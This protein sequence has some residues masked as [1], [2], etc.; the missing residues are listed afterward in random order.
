MR[1]T[2]FLS[3]LWAVAA[4]LF[5]GVSVCGAQPG[6]HATQIE[7]R[8]ADPETFH[9]Q[10][11]TTPDRIWPGAE[12]WPNPME[13]W[14]VHDGRLENLS[15]GVDRN[16]HLLTHVLG[17]PRGS[18]EVRVRTGILETGEQGSVGFRIGQREPEIDDY[19]GNVFYGEGLDAA[20]SVDGTLMLA[21]E[22]TVLDEALPME[23]L[24][25]RLVGEPDE[26][27]YRLTLTVHHVDTGETLGRLSAEDIAGDQVV[28]NVAL[29]NNHTAGGSRFWFSD[30]HVS[31][32]K[33]VAF[34]DRAFGPILWSM[35]SLSNSRGDDGHVLKLSAQMPPLEEQDSDEV[36]LQ[37]RRDG[38][39]ETIGRERIDPDARNAVF[40]ITNWSADRDVPYR[41]VYETKNLEGDLLRDEWKGVIRKDPVEQG[42]LTIASLNC[43]HD[44]GFPYEPVADNV[45]ALDP[46]MLTFHGDQLY[47]SN[48]G[49]GV[50]RDAEEEGIERAIVNY[51][52]KFYMAGWAFREL[53]RDRPTLMMTDDHDVFQ[54]NIWGEAGAEPDGE[55]FST[56]GG[57][58]LPP[59]WVNMVHRTQT[60]HHPDPYDPTPIKQ[61]ISVWYGDMVYGGVSFAILSERMFKSG[62][63]HVDTGEGRADLVETADYDPDDFDRGDLDL[64]GDR[65]MAFLEQWVEDW[66]GAK[67]KVQLG[68]TPYANLN[69]HSGPEGAR[70]FADLDTNAW[71]QSARNDALRILRKGFV[72]H[73]SGDQHLPSVAHYGIDAPGDANWGFC[74]PGISVGWP[75]WWLADEVDE[76]DINNRPDHGLPH[77]GQFLDPFGHPTYLHALGNPTA[78]DGVN[79][80]VRAH[81]KSSG[82]GLL[83]LDTDARTIRMEGYRFLA[84]VDDPTVDNQ[85]PG[86]PVTVGQLTNYGAERVGT[87]PEVSHPEVDRPVVK[88]YDENTDELI[89][90]VRATGSSFEPFVFEED[91]YRVEVGDPDTGQWTVYEEQQVRT[92]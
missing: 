78:L 21:G 6:P 56:T 71:P 69:T 24:E 17:S 84:D 45:A 33:I 4:I 3:F 48:G 87:L 30:W 51:L 20:V 55:N 72:F 59:R 29:V 77:T 7:G 64:L 36:T 8:S 9:S 16:V 2:V 18:F 82:F 34:P 15:D 43:Q 75:R 65:Q 50:V 14:R 5:G 88:V 22:E 76:I 25:L 39:W 91:E 67:M 66:R 42:T 54:G 58:F 89:Y 19:R 79:R 1:S 61:G 62:P 10:F 57:Y 60:A 44:S 80:Y 40:R 32:S 35:Y 12:Y 85:F 27:N 13:D 28:G 92:D 46:D 74:P 49:Y 86:W 81:N 70:L 52:R 37:V 38:Q 73:L 11:A 31:G 83:R 41:L 90:A 68:Q 23:E 63:G 47:E 53:M 26:H